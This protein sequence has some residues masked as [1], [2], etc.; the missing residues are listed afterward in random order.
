MQLDVYL[1]E[2]ANHAVRLEAMLLDAK[3]RLVSEGMLSP[4]E[5]GGALHPFQRK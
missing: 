2:T 1:R 5:T 3:V 4:L